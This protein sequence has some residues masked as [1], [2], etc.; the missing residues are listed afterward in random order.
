MTALAQR[1]DFD[2]M[3]IAANHWNPKNPQPRQEMAIPVAKEKN[4]GVI[5]MKV[6][7]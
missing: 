2:T 5:L 1:G 4:M 3:L 6:V 7:N